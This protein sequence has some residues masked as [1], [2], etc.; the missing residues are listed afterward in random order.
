MV[1]LKNFV[2]A[3]ILVG[4]LLVGASRANAGI[5]Y[6]QKQAKQDV[7]LGQVV[8]RVE[9]KYPG[10]KAEYFSRGFLQFKEQ[11]FV[12]DSEIEEMIQELNPEKQRAVVDPNYAVDG[13]N[14]DDDYCVMIDSNSHHIG[15]GE[16][17]WMPIP[18]PEGTVYE[19][20]FIIK[21]LEEMGNLRLSMEVFSSDSKNKVYLNGIVVG[22]VPKME[23]GKW[24]D[25][26]KKYRGETPFLYGE[27]KIDNLKEG[28]NVV[29]IES[30][31]SGFLFKSYD[32]FMMRRVQIVYNK[33]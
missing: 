21:D 6:S 4:A 20:K 3:G 9:K 22:M 24:G 19:K 14:F 27:L 12:K 26:M 7:K 5:L 1:K 11:K 13:V 29:R 10:K 31:K 17:D 28:E 30:E 32:D 25:L 16:K 2:R 15:D 18:K 33:K 23:K 8:K